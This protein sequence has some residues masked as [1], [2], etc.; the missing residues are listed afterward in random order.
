ML[1]RSRNGKGKLTYND[2]SYY[3]GTFVDGEKN[4]E[5]LYTRKNGSQVQEV[6]DHGTKVE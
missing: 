6:W 1:F 3:E 5:G 4:G 2:G